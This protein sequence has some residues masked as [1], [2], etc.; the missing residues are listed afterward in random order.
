M[1]VS[2]MVLDDRFVV[3]VVFWDHLY[4]FDKLKNS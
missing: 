3:V 4:R 2:V 1:V